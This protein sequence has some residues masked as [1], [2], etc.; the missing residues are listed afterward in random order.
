[1]SYLRS[2]LTYS[3]IVF[4]LGLFGLLFGGLVLSGET[5]LPTRGGGWTGPRAGAVSEKFEV[6]FPLLCLG[7]GMLVACWKRASWGE[8]AA[9]LVLCIGVLLILEPGGIEGLRYVLWQVE[10]IW[11]E[12][13]RQGA[14]P[15]WTR[16]A[17]GLVLCQTSFF[18]QLFPTMS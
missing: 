3:A 13:F 12:T 4:L 7:M 17:T 18:D 5:T 8:S 10:R 1:M 2:A 6:G 9:A 14:A 11:E 16:A 15:E